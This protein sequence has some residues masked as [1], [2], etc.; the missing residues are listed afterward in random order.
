MEAVNAPKSINRM[1]AVIDGGLNV[2]AVVQTPPA[3]QKPKLLDQVREAIRTRHYSYRTEKAYVHWVKRFIFFHNKRHPAE[4]GE[5]EIGRFLSALATELQVSASTQNQAL[6]A[7]LFLY[8]E[9]LHKQIGFVDGVVRQS[10][11][12]VCPSC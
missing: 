11:H 7:L 4:M 2:K 6:N 12:I 5:V 3:I 10:G 8:K 9:V 1:L